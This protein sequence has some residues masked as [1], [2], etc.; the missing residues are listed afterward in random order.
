MYHAL[1]IGCGNIGALYDL[2]SEQVLTHAKAYFLHPDF[3]LAVYDPDRDLM[4]RIAGLYD[5]EVVEEPNDEL[6]RK[7]DCVSICSPTDT[8]VPLLRMA[9]G[10]G[11]PLVICEKP[12]SNNSGLL[13]ELLQEYLQHNTRVLVNYIRRFQ[14][15]FVR[16][17]ECIREWNN[18]E[19]LRHISIRYQRGFINNASHAFDLLQFLLD[20]PMKLD[21]VHVSHAAPDHFT[22]DPTI[23]LTANW[24]GAVVDVVGLSYVQYAHFEVDLFFTNHKVSIANA[25]NQIRISKAEPSDGALRPLSEMEMIEGG[26]RDYMKPV[27]TLANEMLQDT[28]RGDNFAEALALNQHLLEIINQ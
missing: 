24:D 4:T 9:M 21:Q 19:V 18:T 2:N 17:R 11:V 27:I 10:S 8:H 5:A 13:P 22:K 15:G 23:S 14:P 20:S 28:K 6:M 1:L 26:I 7:F 25:G 16:L 3:S 12:L